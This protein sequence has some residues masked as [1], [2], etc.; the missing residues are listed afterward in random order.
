MDT[1]TTSQGLSQALLPAG[2][3]VVDSAP[4]GTVP[5]LAVADFYGSTG[6]YLLAF[7]KGRQHVPY[8]GGTS[9]RSVAQHYLGWSEDIGR[10][11]GEHRHPELGRAAKLCEAVVRAGYELALVRVWFGVD[12]EFERL[13]KHRHDN[14][15][16]CPWCL[17]HPEPAEQ[18]GP[19]AS[20]LD[21]GAMTTAISSLSALQQPPLFLPASASSAADRRASAVSSM[22][23]QGL[24]GLQGLLERLCAFPCASDDH[25]C[26]AA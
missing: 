24:Q 14:A 5:G 10:R 16:Y 3:A 21:P 11:V 12:R 17:W 25:C 19:C 6:C 2:G 23:L 7:L 20:T 26:D 22:G 8:T 9:P 13:L 15:A 18:A 1:N 4:R